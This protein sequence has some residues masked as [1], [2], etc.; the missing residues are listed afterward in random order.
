MKH[1]RSILLVV[2]GILFIL[3]GTH[4]IP[5]LQFDYGE[6]DSAYSAV[7]ILNKFGDTEARYICMAIERQTHVLYE[8]ES[9]IFL[10]AGL[11][12][13]ICAIPKAKS[14]DSLN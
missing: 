8:I 2:T 13:L 7:S 1:I 11:V 9:M 12:M 5:S 4:N 6:Y 3:I 10:S 14:N